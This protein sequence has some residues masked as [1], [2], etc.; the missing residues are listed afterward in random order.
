MALVVRQ[1][2]I[3]TPKFLTFVTLITISAPLQKSARTRTAGEPSYAVTSQDSV[4]CVLNV[5]KRIGTLKKILPLRVSTVEKHS[6]AATSQDSVRVQSVLNVKKRIGI[7]KKILLLCVSTVEEHSYAVTSK[8]SV[9]SVLNVEKRIGIL[10]A[11]QVNN[12]S[13]FIARLR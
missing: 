8:D 6:N 5:K 1:Y 12:I 13:Y 9:Q 11:K 10:Y 4:Q 2:T 3:V 7:F